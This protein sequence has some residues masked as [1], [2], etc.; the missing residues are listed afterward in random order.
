MPSSPLTLDFPA[1]HHR[2]VVASFDGGDITSDAG[3]LLV[4]AADRKAG[5]TAA[6]TAAFTDTRDQKKVVHGVADL[7]RERIYAI[8]QGYEDANDLDRLKDDPALKVACDR[9]PQ[10]VARLRCQARRELHTLSRRD[11]RVIPN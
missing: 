1:V 10:I 5:V 6:L 2:P 3:V 8:A 7:L 9:L 11:K 4:A